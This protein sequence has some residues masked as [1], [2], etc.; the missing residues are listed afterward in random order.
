MIR[1]ISGT[2]GFRK[3]NR[4]IPKNSKSAPFEV[5]AAEEKRLI[6]L[7]IAEKVEIEVKEVD[8]TPADD[9][10]Y[11]EM[12]VKQLKEYCKNSGISLPKTATTKEKII[13]VIT[14]N[15]D[16]NEAENG[17]NETPNLQAKLPE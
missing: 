9:S 11:A 15:N 1:I 6:E 5:S 17:E 14:A 2:Y 7:G 4:V 13:E 3:E 12:P 10:N 8:E 16:E